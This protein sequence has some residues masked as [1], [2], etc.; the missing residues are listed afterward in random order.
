MLALAQR[1]TTA[2][3]D[4]VDAARGLTV[5]LMLLVN[6]PVPG[7][8]TFPMLTHMP[9]HGWTVA[10]AVYP[11]FLW[12]VGVS[13]ALAFRTS[14]TLNHA[15]IARRVAMLWLF[16]LFLDNVPY[17]ATGTLKLNGLL[18]Q[19]AWCYLIT[20]YLTAR[21]TAKVVAFVVVALLCFQW[22]AFAVIGTDDQGGL[23]LTPDLNGALMLDQ[24]VFG[25]GLVHLA[26]GSNAFD[27]LVLMAG[28]LATTLGG[29]LCG[30]WLLRCQDDRSRVGRLVA[31]GALCLWTGWMASQ[32]VPINKP[33]WTPSFA[34]W[35][36]G[37]SALVLAAVVVLH[38]KVP[39]LQPLPLARLAGRHALFLYV[40]AWCYQRVI[41]HGKWSLDSGETVRLKTALQTHWPW[42][43][44][45]SFVFSVCFLMLCLLTLGLTSWGRTRLIHD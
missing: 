4:V 25:P 8:P 3:D 13:V 45:G 34:L 11:M 12:L 33:L 22:I 44:M 29:W 40:L 1:P 18:A 27:G 26:N 38:A 7:R 9:W 39:T 10:D 14:G 31:V 19:I 30:T 36:A 37:W 43:T 28:L 32:V 20:T 5:G 21:A 16:S 42:E 17:Y 35:M 23:N 24:W 6:H 15:R 2:R 41:A